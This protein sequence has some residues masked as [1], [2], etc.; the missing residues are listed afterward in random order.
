[1]NGYILWR[2]SSSTDVLWPL[3]VWSNVL[4]SESRS[5]K[6]PENLSM[7]CHW[8]K[9]FIIS[10]YIVLFDNKIKPLICLSCSNYIKPFFSSLKPIL[11]IILLVWL[12]TL[13]PATCAKCLFQARIFTAAAWHMTQFYIMCSKEYIYLY[14]HGM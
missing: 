11:L 9:P 5:R 1:M 7:R 8:W 12:R 2:I 10:F 4:K 3:A 13:M 14:I 6:S